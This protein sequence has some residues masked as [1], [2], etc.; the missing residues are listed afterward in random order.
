MTTTA[1][2]LGI[3]DVGQVSVNARDLPRAVGFYRDVLGLPLLF[4][5][6]GAAFFQCGPLRLIVGKAEKP[7]FD[8]PG[9]I[10]YYRVPDIH[11]AWDALV[12]QGVRAEQEPHLLAK[13]PTY[14]LWMAFFRDTED[15]YLALMSEVP[16]A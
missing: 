10:L 9:S 12:R 6:P 14:D 13:M 15:N 7:E 16:R 5:I 11:A 4:E 8:H 2:A 1:G 3:T